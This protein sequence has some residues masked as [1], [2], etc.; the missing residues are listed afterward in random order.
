MAAMG[1]MTGWVKLANFGSGFEADIVAERLRGAGI[2]ATTRG[3]DIVGIFG[4]GFQGV[5]ARGVDVLVPGDELA[6]ARSIL[7]DD[8][9][10]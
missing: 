3:N 1:S 5:T 2:H 8:Q 7:A 9:D 4:A 6:K 10:G